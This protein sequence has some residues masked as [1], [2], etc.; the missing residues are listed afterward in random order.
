MT[1]PITSLYAAV[2]AVI[3]LVLT[4]QVIKARSAAGISILHGDDMNLAM[5]IRIHGNFAEFVPLA[6][7]LLALAEISGSNALALN[8]A[9]A[10]L[11]VSRILI[12]FGLDI[13]RFNHPV[14]IIGN[15]GTHIAIVICV[16]L[17]G[18]AQFS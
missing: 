10:A 12:P 2:L 9:G 4:M 14:R 13:E 6:L 16:V 17:I 3:F 15:L 5:K 8:V 11:V 1:L 7:I 18:I